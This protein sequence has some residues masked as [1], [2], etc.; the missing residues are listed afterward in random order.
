V[1]HRREHDLKDESSDHRRCVAELPGSFVLD[2]E[3]VIENP[4][5]EDCGPVPRD[6][7]RLKCDTSCNRYSGVLTKD[8][9]NRDA[10]TENF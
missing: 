6:G 4:E 2:G 8:A 7:G 3:A 10:L 1:L 9:A 5:P